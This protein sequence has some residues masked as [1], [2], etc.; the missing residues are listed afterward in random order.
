MVPRSRSGID[1]I[2]LEKCLKIME[3]GIDRLFPEVGNV[4]TNH[5]EG[6]RVG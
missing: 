6:L 3:A 5:F 2:C 4:R 1:I